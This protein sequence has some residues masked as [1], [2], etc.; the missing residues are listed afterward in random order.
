M[1]L[2]AAADFNQFSEILVSRGKRVGHDD[3]VDEGNEKDQQ[4][5]QSKSLVH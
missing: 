1:Y 3:R 4:E 5:A 2:A